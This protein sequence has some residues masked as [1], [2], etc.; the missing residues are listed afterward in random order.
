MERKRPSPA[1]ENY[2]IFLYTILDESPPATLTKLAQHLRV[3]AAMESMGTTLP[4]IDG[5]LKRLK[6]DGL[7]EISPQKEITFTPVGHQMAT[8]VFRHHQLAERFLTDMLGVEL[9]RVHDE[10]MR[11]Q[12]VMTPE[13]EAKI[14]Q[15][16]NNPKTCPFG[17][18]IPG[19]GYTGN[20]RAVPLQQLTAGQRGVVER[21]PEE[22]PELIKYFV[23]NDIRPGSHIEFKEYAPYKGTTT[24]VISG[25]EVVISP[26][27]AANVWVEPQN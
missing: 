22:D 11:W 3:S 15:V 20:P 1:A 13:V 23:E 8:E 4:T 16:L 24:L 27:I 9:H 26:A 19:S 18:P 5:M 21:I 10:A 14:A 6:R 12:H 25:R 2:L 17:H 7:I